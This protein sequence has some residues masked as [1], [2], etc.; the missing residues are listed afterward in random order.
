MTEQTKE[1]IDLG[2]NCGGCG[3]PLTIFNAGGYQHF[4]EKCVVVMP[5][6]PRDGKAHHI[7]GEYPNFR[8]V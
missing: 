7:E 4:C 6:F 5:S 8:W 2:V 3:A 1:D